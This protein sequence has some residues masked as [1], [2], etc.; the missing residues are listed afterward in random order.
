MSEPF[1]GEIRMVGFNFA[2]MGWALC[3]GQT[4]PIQ[5]YTAL[6]SLLGTYYGGNG[7]TTFQLPDLQSRVPV[8]QGQGAGLSP[9]TIGEQTGTENVTL[10]TSQMPS[11]NHTVGVSNAA[12]TLTNPTNNTLAQNTTTPGREPVFGPPNFVTTGPTGTLAPGTISLAGGSQPH[13]N[14]QPVLC[15]NFIIALQGIFPSRS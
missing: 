14:I 10:I 6:F 3:N 4:L 11:H 2:P 5:Q 15:V 13:N 9:Y 12:G 7:Q 8:H 1:I